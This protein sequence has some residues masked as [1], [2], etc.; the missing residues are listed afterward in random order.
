MLDPRFWNNPDRARTISQRAQLLRKELSIWQK[1]ET[2]CAEALDTAKEDVA[3]FLKTDVEELYQ[4]IQASFSKLEFFVLMNGKY[5]D[6]NA[7]VSIHS[8]A[9]GVDAQDWA[10]MLQRM[11]LRFCENEGWYVEIIEES[12]GGEAGIKSMTMRVEGPHAYGFLKAEAGVH[13]LVRISPFDA[14]AMR[15][16]SFALVDVIPELPNTGEIGIAESDMRIDVYR[17]SGHG[18]QGV[19]TTD[20]AVR[21]VHIPTGI[22]VT[23]Q[24]ERSQHQN[25]AT[26]MAI[27]RGKLATLEEENREKEERA[28]RG[29]MVSADWGNQIRS[30]VL[31]PY[32][33]VK[34]HRTN[35]ERSDPDV[36][37]DG[38]ILPFIEAYL[39]W[40]KSK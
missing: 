30:Y 24:N 5:D 32:K 25:K 26:A 22:T 21:I 37:L 19:N 18:G 29:E 31:H 27:L 7:I 15:H 16:T 8:G 34:D 39:R 38:D 35:M 23:C 20:S 40:R 12:R 10:Q 17:A 4:S 3:G 28:L 2:D 13:R 11:Y 6:L 36:V 9:G 33:L 14:E 1:L